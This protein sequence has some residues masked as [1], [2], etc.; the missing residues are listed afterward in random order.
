[1]LTD[2]LSARR[3]PPI[4]AAVIAFAAL[5]FLIPFAMHHAA[6]LQGYEAEWTARQIVAGNGFSV[7]G[8]HRHLWY[9]LDANALYPT[10]WVDPVFTYTLAAAHLLFGDNANQAIVVLN[11]LALGGA[12]IMGYKLAARFGGQWVGVLAVTFIAF[13]THFLRGFIGIDNAPLGSFFILL[14]AYVAVR[15]FEKSAPRRLIM[16]G[17]LT[18]LALLACPAVQYLAYG[19][20]VAVAAN[21]AILKEKR[22]A[23]VRP[24]AMLV[25]VALV[26]TPWVIRNYRVFDEI[27]LVRNGAGQMAYVG[28]VAAAETFMPG[29]AKSSLPAPWTS[30]GPH[31]AVVKMI[32]K[33][34]RMAL[35]HYQVDAWVAT[36]PPNYERMNEAQRDKLYFKRTK[37]FMRAHPGPFIQ[38]GVTKLELFI[39]KYGKYG[40]GL[41][42]L[43]IVGAVLSIRDARSWPLSL[44]AASYA[45]P[46]VLIVAYYDRYRLPIEPVLAVLSAVAIGRA[47][48]Y[49]RV[50]YWR[51]G[52]ESQSTVANMG[53][54]ITA[55]N[56]H[57][58]Q[59]VGRFEQGRA[60][61]VA[62][63][64]EGRT[65]ALPSNVKS[66]SKRP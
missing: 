2:Y 1:M 42:A 12:M 30:E 46:F 63:V 16:M 21:H 40:L 26:L 41:V 8:S 28:T 23:I 33:P 4:G 49:A 50:R 32:Q 10:A 9:G 31:D 56:T 47:F 17:L 38:M 3:L 53:K 48:E 25:L 58:A 51:L 36:P 6:H 59:A 54:K 55:S 65:A 57:V 61:F 22:L 35:N 24:I 39:F 64:G 45:A 34:Y 7:A 5:A 19:I 43:A 37:E 15:Y 52:R 13:H 62:C 11:F 18:G 60:E 14:T 44:A 66:A 29:A 27:V 20:A